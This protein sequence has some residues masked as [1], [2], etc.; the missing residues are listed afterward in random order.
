MQLVKRR[1]IF[2]QSRGGQPRALS[3][4]QTAGAAYAA[5]LPWDITYYSLFKSL[6]YSKLTVRYRRCTMIAGNVRIRPLR[7]FLV[8]LFALALTPSE[9]AASS[10]PYPSLGIVESALLTTASDDFDGSA[11]AFEAAAKWNE[12]KLR[13]SGQ[14]LAPHIACTRYGRGRET[15]SRL[16]GLLSSEA[17]RPLSQSREHGS[18]FLAT[19]S[20]AQVG[21]IAAMRDR[22]GLESLAPF[23]SVLKLAPGLLEHPTSIRTGRLSTNHGRSM[24]MDSVEGLTVELS[25]GAL[26]KQSFEANGFLEDLLEDLMSA[27][28]DLRSSNV[29]SDPTMLEGEHLTTPGGTVRGHEWSKA[30]ALVHELSKSGKTSPADICSWDS[31]SVHHSADDVLLVKGVYRGHCILC[32]A[33]FG[34][35]TKFH[36]PR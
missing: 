10:L 5:A 3:L 13:A 11:T 9:S 31:V 1:T 18:C 36:G 30:A 28:L 12:E 4:P 33:Y 22:F 29:W 23:P 15:L 8:F 26:S 34:F 21:V 25:P 35:H 2:S 14:V 17:V 27:S 20:H 16:E 19:A 6:D 32:F 24:R 7:V